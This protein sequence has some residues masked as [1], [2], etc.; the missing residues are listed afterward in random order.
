MIRTL[1][2]NIRKAACD[3]SGGVAVEFALSMFPLMA[4][5][6]G[7]I[8]YSGLLASLLVLNHAAS[9]GARAAVA[10]TTLCERRDRA[11]DIARRSLVF[12]PIV[13]TAQVSAT[14]TADE[15]TLQIVYAYKQAPLTP[16]LFF[17]PETLTTSM[18]AHTDGPEYPA[19]EC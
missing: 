10:G 17:V 1:C 9:E 13:D 8:T 11:V 19:G 18:V 5:L 3:R 12:G 6:L 14:V 15:V 7:G 4:L 2:A 16:V